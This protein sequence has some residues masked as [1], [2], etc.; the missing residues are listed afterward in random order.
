MFVGDAPKP[1]FI[2]SPPTG[3]DDS[4]FFQFRAVHEESKANLK[5]VEKQVFFALPSVSAKPNK[6]VRAIKV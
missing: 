2:I 3:K 4:L 5:F 6:G 1:T